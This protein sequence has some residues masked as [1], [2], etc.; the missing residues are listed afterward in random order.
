MAVID[1]HLAAPAH[2]PILL[3]SAPAFDVSNQAHKTVTSR[4]SPR[5]GTSCQLLK[6]ISVVHA[7]APSLLQP[8]RYYPD[9]TALGAHD[10]VP[11]GEQVKETILTF[12]FA[13]NSCFLRSHLAGVCGHMKACSRTKNSIAQGLKYEIVDSARSIHFLSHSFSVY[14]PFTSPQKPSSC[15]LPCPIIPGS[16]F[17]SHSGHRGSESYHVEGKRSA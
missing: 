5:A 17:G 15:L 14:G 12:D 8:R 11:G 7:R 16:V 6:S 4:P 10:T 2:F 3:H 13:S 9:M 1:S